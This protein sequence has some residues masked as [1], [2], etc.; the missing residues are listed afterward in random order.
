MFCVD[1]G[2]IFDM[3]LPA[4]AFGAPAVETPRLVDSTGREHPIRPGAQ[5]IGREADIVTNDPKASR[6]HA[7]IKYLNGIAVIEDLGS[8]N[9]TTVNGVKLAPGVEQ[10]LAQGDKIVFGGAEMT[11]AM[12]GSLSANATAAIASN[13]TAAI[14]APPRVEAAPARLVGDGVSYPLKAGMNKFG[15]KAEND[16]QIS[17]P[18]VSGSHGIIE[19]TDEGVFLVDTGSTNGTVLNDAKLVPNMR[20]AITADDVIRLGSLEFRVIVEA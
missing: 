17:D 11:F 20:T 7:Q 14:S 3:A 5:T 15:R 1:C 18:Y 10:T 9:G 16:V 4:D 19:V 2:L 12:P 13:R 6:R 8:T